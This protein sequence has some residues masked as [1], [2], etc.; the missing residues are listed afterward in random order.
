M[1]TKQPASSMEK[2]ANI[3]Q[4]AFAGGILAGA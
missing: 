4:R 3:W 2:P 1:N